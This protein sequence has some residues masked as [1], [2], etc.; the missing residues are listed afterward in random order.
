MDEDGKSIY[1]K[2][3]DTVLHSLEHHRKVAD[4]QRYGTKALENLAQRSG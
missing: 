1:Q 4:V 2:V 3:T